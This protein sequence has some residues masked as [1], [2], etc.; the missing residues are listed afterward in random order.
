MC[1]PHFK[2]IKQKSKLNG[3]LELFFVLEILFYNCKI[4]NFKT[5]EISNF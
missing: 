2:I 5:F 4:I 3:T 1:V